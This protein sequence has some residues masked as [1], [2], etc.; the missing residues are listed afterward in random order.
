MMR[1]WTT[2]PADAASSASSAIDSSA[3]ASDP[4]AT[5]TRMVRSRTSA[6]RAVRRL[7]A[8]SSSSELM[9]DWKSRSSCDGIFGSRKAYSSGV[10]AL[11]R[12]PACSGSKCAARTRPGNPDSASTSIAAMR[13]RRRSARSV[14]S[15]CVSGSPRKCVCTQRSP[16]NLPEA[17]RTRLKSGSSMRRLSPTITY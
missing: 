2:T 14:K 7:R 4:V 1:S 3:S 5:P 12:S 13:S 8:I 17:T 10:V 6:R 9:S 16:R 11:S 15:S